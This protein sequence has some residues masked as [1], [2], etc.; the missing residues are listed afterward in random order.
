MKERKVFDLEDRLLDF[1]V[2][3]ITLFVGTN[4]F[5]KGISHGG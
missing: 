5:V 2:G 4:L 3:V 1:A